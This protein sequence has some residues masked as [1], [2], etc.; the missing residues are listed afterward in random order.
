METAQ[1]PEP[2][3]HYGLLEEAYNNLFVLYWRSEARLELMLEEYVECSARLEEVS[4]ELWECKSRMEEMR[5]EHK[6]LA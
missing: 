6:N 3:D 5:A 4:S 1:T 2:L